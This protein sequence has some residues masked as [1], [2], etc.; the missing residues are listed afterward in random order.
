MSG[1]PYTVNFLKVR[2]NVDFYRTFTLKSKDEDDVIA[3]INLASATL[4][5]KWRPALDLTATPVVSLAVGTGISK[6]DSANGKLSVLIDSAVMAL[7]AP[8]KYKYDL[9][10]V[11]AGLSETVMEGYVKVVQGA[12]SL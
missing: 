9:V 4:F 3:P 11:R 7:I 1:Q 8:G 12:T 5:M 2:N 6:T 10:L